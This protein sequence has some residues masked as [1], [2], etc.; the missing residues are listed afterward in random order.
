M[1]TVRVISSLFLSLFFVVLKAANPVPV[2]EKGIHW[3]SF[4]EMQQA[5]KVKPK[6]VIIDIYTG[7]CG[8]CKKMDKT[9]FENPAVADYVNENFYAVKFDAESKSPV[10]FSGKK[11][12]NPNRYHDLA[13]MLMNG[14]MGFPTSVY[15]DEKLQPLT[16]PIASYLDAK[17]FETIIN[18]LNTESYKTMPF[19]KYQEQ[20]KSKAQ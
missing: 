3:L 4:D 8:W 14:Q 20:F 12:E 2:A 1:A 7:W 11:Y 15:L 9:T 13:V 18:Y 6:K 5:Q 19:D 16:A 17:Q 10:S